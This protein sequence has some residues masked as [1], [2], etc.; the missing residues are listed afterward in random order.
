MNTRVRKAVF[1]RRSALP[2]SAACVVANGVRET[3]ASLLRTSVAI[4]LLEPGI[5][6]AAAWPAILKGTDLYRVRG[7]LADAAIV[8]R[9]GDALAL[10]AALFGERPAPQRERELSPIER[11]L[12]E[13]AIRA[14]AAHLGAVCGTRETLLPE[15]VAR[16]EGFATYFELLLE[17]PV[18]ARIGIALSR[19]PVPESRNCFEIAHLAAVNLIAHATLDL[20]AIS[21]GAIARLVCGATLAVRPFDF[22]RCTLRLHGRGLA[23]GTCGVRHGRFAVRVESICESG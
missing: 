13:R 3:L 8:L 18:V 12:L 22:G 16:I 20:D 5:P 6:S 15:R 17:G 11:D 7:A 23:R 10:A 1:G 9:R 14:M 21:A 2:A 19:E 4:R